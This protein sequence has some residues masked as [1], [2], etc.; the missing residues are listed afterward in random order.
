[1]TIELPRSRAVRRRLVRESD[2][3][4]D[5]HESSRAAYL[6]AQLEPGE[7]VIARQ[8]LEVRT[9]AVATITDR[10]IIFAWHPVTTSDGAWRHDA[11]AFD[12][13]T[14]WSMGRRH[15][16][17]PML[18]L[19]HPAH[20]RP[21]QVPGHRFLWFAWGDAEIDEPHTETTFMFGRSRNP[22]FAWIRDELWRREIPEGEPFV[23]A[24]AGT[25]DERLGEPGWLTLEE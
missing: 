22:V 1:M 21:V 2:A 18:R 17:G 9:N 24:P 10:R 19:E 7:T 5:A 23:D 3:R 14:R 25:R 12:E 8:G 16:G 4:H 20:A 13:V 15:D 11:V 6:A